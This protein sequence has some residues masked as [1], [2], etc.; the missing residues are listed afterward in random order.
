MAL[1]AE[2]ED[3]AVPGPEHPALALERS[4]ALQSQKE[5]EGISPAQ[6]TRQSLCSPCQ[7][8]IYG[9]QELG[10]V[11][12][13]KPGAA[14]GEN[15]AYSAV[16]DQLLVGSGSFWLRKALQGAGLHCGR[17][18]GQGS[19]GTVTIRFPPPTQ[20]ALG[21]RPWGGRWPGPCYCALRVI[22]AASRLYGAW[23]AQDFSSCLEMV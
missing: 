22:S 12:E 17:G 9:H 13:K 10:E 1:K 11:T 3:A 5:G 14:L 15:A 21:P 23:T 18:E 20:L 6:A 19:Q 7:E 4:C 8:R 2:G 16:M